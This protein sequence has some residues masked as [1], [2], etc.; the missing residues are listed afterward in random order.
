MLIG[1]LNGGGKTTLLDALQLCLFGPHAK[2][3]N[4]GSLADQEYLSRSIHRG[5]D[6]SQ[7]A[8]KVSFRRTVDGREERYRLER[9]WYR[10]DNGCKEQF[11]VF[12]D[13]VE[14]LALSDNWVTQV[15]EFFPANIAHL[16]LFDGDKLKHTAPNKSHRL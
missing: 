6:I 10:T 14:D 16:F 3:S 8:V 1:G 12:L 7:A 11:R 15:E 4:R 2:I 13:D 5:P 9:T